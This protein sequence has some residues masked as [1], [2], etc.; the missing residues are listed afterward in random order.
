MENGGGRRRRGPARPIGIN[1]ENGVRGGLD[2]SGEEPSWSD[3]H[4]G[5]RP[6]PGLWHPRL[7]PTHLHTHIHTHAHIH[8]HTPKHAEHPTHTDTLTLTQTHS[9][10]PWQSP[11]C[12]QPSSQP[13]SFLRYGF[14][15]TQTVIIIIFFSS[16]DFL[17]L[18]EEPC[19]FAFPSSPSHAPPPLSIPLLFYFDFSLN[20][21]SFPLAASCKFLFIIYLFISLRLLQPLK[22]FFSWQ[23]C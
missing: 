4:R 18:F 8:T 21:I 13:P 22:L 12:S 1:T 20:L 7:S 17:K 23:E 6:R 10:V 9:S 5:Q 16:F 19:P 14:I 3:Q 11:T 2:N 15:S